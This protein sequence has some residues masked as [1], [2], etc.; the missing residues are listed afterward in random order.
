MT[1]RPLRIGVLGAASIT[2]MAL[3]R[4]ARVL[5]MGDVV[6]SAV[7]ARDVKRARRFAAAHGIATVCDDYAALLARDDVDA[8][9]NPLPNSH[10]AWRSLQ[11]ASPPRRS[12]GSP[13]AAPAPGS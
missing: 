11:W 8:I 7:A 1:V 9:Y 5:G 10:H 13:D 6:I 4:P 3:L 12:A 2:P